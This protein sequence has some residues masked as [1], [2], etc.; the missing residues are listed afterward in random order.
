M[1]RYIVTVR[2]IHRVPVSVEADTEDD[3]I[4]EA[5]RVIE[6]DES[7][8]NAVPDYEQTLEPDEWIITKIP[9]DATVGD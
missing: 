9:E 8:V 7:Y 4:E 1:S 2:E 6:E 3:A 5:Q